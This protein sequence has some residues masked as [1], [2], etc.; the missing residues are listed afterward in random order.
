MLTLF[1]I[2]KPF[3]GLIGVIQR[4]AIESWRRLQGCEVLLLGNEEGVEGVARECGARWV[5]NVTLNDL[6]TP[7]L[8][9]AFRAARDNATHPLLCYVN[10]DIILFPDL[11]E[12]VGAVAFTDFLMA[13]RR[14]NIDLTSPI[15]FRDAQWEPK[16]RR[17]VRE[18]AT[19]YTEY[20]SDFFVLAR[21]SALVEL[22]AFAV[23]RPRWDNWLIYRARKLGM[24][25]ID[26]TE[27]VTAVHQNH[28]YSHIPQG[29]DK[30]WGG[31]E[32]DRNLEL[33]DGGRHHF[34]LMTATHVLKSGR[35]MPALSYP[36]L[37]GRLYAL[38]HLY[39]VLAPLWAVL[40]AVKR[41]ILTLFS[42]AT[43]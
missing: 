24:P 39:P 43:V 14:W 12:A 3:R 5:P 37:R 33:A 4:N 28:D 15:D 22:P 42:R 6:G 38:P 34:S 29:R 26:A 7:L 21:D 41:A 32:A 30:S 16:I 25:V 9:S 11:L 35:V 40:R 27:A 2:P 1:S 19:L 23:G 20:G 8:D 18:N 10:A 31:P 36:Y 17:S 13:G